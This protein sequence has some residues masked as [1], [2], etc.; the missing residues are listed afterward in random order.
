MDVFVP[1]P[2]GRLTC[3]PGDDLVVRSNDAVEGC[4]IIAWLLSG[5]LGLG[6]GDDQEE[7]Q[8]SEH[9]RLRAHRKTSGV[10]GD[11][12]GTGW[13]AA[14]KPSTTFQAS[15]PDRQKGAPGECSLIL[16]DTRT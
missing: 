2:V 15:Y 6:T 11:T 5:P 7:A 1:R 9:V 8:G 10:H 12:S 14:F 13:G 3:R 4:H 16:C